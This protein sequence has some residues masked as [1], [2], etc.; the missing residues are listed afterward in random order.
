MAEIQDR[1]G[2][3]AKSKANYAFFVFNS[4]ETSHLLSKENVVKNGNDSE[5]K[6]VSVIKKTT[7]KQKNTNKPTSSK[8]HKKTFA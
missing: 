5:S 2:N 6:D 1:M 3:T 4:V 7:T 8:N